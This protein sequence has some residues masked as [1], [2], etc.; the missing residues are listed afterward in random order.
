MSAAV[1]TTGRLLRLSPVAAGDRLHGLRRLAAVAAAGRL[2]RLLAVG[3][4]R[5]RLAIAARLRGARGDWRRRIVAGLNWRRLLL[6]VAGLDGWWLRW[7][8][9]LA[10]SLRWWRGLLAVSL[11]WWRG[12]LSV[13]RCWLWWLAAIG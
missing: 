12:L 13:A 8:G 10:V 2:L 7:W 9:L 1:S 5:P 6:A 4:L 11:R 3:R